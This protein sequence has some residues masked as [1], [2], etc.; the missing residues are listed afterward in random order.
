MGKKKKDKE[1][2]QAK[3]ER[4]AE[5][6]SKKAQKKAKKA[7]KASGE[8]D[9]DAILQEFAAQEAAKTAISMEACEQPGPRTNFSLCCGSGANELVLFGG[10]YFDGVDTRCFNDLFKV[11]ISRAGEV[12]WTSVTSP[13][14]PLPRCSHQSV[15]YRDEMYIFGGE[16]TTTTQFHHYG[17]FWKLNLK[18]HA[19]QQ[20]QLVGDHPSP[21]SGHRMVVWRSYLVLFGGFYEATRGTR[22]FDELYVMNFA[23]LR[24]QRVEKGPLALWPTPRSGFG[25]AAH[26][27]QDLAYVFGGYAK[28][29]DGKSKEE[30]K[31]STDVWCLRLRPVAT[32]GV[33]TWERV[34]RKGA[35]PS[36]RSGAACVVHKTRTL[37]FGGVFDTEGKKYSLIST[38]FNDLYAFDMDRRRYYELQLKQEKAAGSSRRRR[39]GRQGTSAGGG[40][41]GGDIAEEGGEGDGED[42]EDEEDDAADDDENANRFGF[43]DDAS[44]K[45]VYISDEDED[46]D[47]A[48]DEV[49]EGRQA[50]ASPAEKPGAEGPADLAE[51]QE[52]AAEAA[53]AAASAEEEEEKDEEE[54]EEG[55]ALPSAPADAPVDAPADAPADAVPS[56]A[57]V[58]GPCARINCGLTMLGNRMVLYG[59]ITE[60][61]EK[62]VTLDDMWLLDL[63]KRTGWVKLL[64]GRYRE[65]AWRGASDRKGEEDDEDG[66]DDYDEEDEEGDSDDEEMP[67]DEEDSAGEE[68]GG[69]GA[70]EEKAGDAAAAAADEQ[71]GGVAEDEGTVRREKKEK[72]EKKKKKKKQRATGLRA[73]IAELHEQLATDDAATTPLSGETTRDFFART[74]EH[75]VR[76]LMEERPSVEERMSEKEMR[77]EAFAIASRRYAELEPILRELDELEAEQRDAER[78]AVDAS[79]SGKHRSKRG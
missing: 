1:A 5:K 23:D 52:A 54:E 26:A 11:Q 62:E 49:A 75:W 3:K 17:D 61:G 19:W 29:K 71:E 45:M 41:G 50:A 8:Q 70:E 32:G 33:P 72:K 4:A 36:P 40:E 10:E 14:S 21:R 31:L 38:F 79:R 34:S 64:E 78:D 48:E 67:S 16:F 55:S 68:E 57:P 51:A 43:W 65:Q 35:A 20:L 24:W 9:I 6:A 73:R 74:A 63:S 44:G 76:R 7:S 22:W 69:R 60:E 47:A 18:T 12:Q 46:E 30:A 56:A 27:S 39:R 13:N 77:R 25:M 15:V 66:E 59:G 2:R 58:F 53:L 28:V 37:T 42:G